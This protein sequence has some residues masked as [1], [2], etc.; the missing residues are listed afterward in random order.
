MKTF[1]KVVVWILAIILV[2]ILVSYVL[3]KTYKVDRSVTIKARPE[4]VYDITSNFNKWK[5]WIPWTKA[6][7]STAVFEL[8]GK[9][10]QAGTIWKW[11]GKVLGSGQMTSTAYTPGQQMDYDLEF[12]NGKYKSKGKILIEKNADSCKVTWSDEGDLGYNPI[13]RYFGL[14]MDRILGPDFVKGLTKLKSV[15]EARASWPRIEE[16]SIPGQ[17]AILIRDSAGPKTYEKVMG[18]GFGELSAFV[19]GNK[20]KIV[21]HP[22]AIYVKYDT[23]TMNGVMDIGFLVENADKGKGRVRVE[24]LPAHNVVMAYYIGPYDKMGDTYRAL[25]Q[26]I[27]EAELQI[28]GGPCEIYVNDPMSEK[29]PAK[30]ETDVLFPVK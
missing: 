21:G 2:L 27:K 29:D 5:L 23:V 19:K 25:H 16:K 4:L 18:K 20:L 15:C 9:E 12:D 7:D 1:K 11:N 24:T 13:S 10:G 17:I 14:F 6:V 30:L 26:Y 28:T 3:P 8:I 22:F